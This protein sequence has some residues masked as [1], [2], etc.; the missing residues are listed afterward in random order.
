M[1]PSLAVVCR[2]QPVD[3][4]GRVPIVADGLVFLKG[5]RNA[6]QRVGTAFYSLRSCDRL[7]RGGA[8]LQRESMGAPG[9]KQWRS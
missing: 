6:R 9:G 5:Y 2:A 7:G 3:S 1:R 8:A 4:P